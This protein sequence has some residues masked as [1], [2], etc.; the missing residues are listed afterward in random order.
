MKEELTENIHQAFLQ[1]EFATKLLT[2]TE[3]Y[4][5][6]KNDFDTNVVIEDGKHIIPFNHSAFNSYDDLIL[7]AENNYNITLGFTAIVLDSSFEKIG[8]AADPKNRTSNGMLRT[9]IYM[10]RC[11][12]AH[13]MMF[14]KW[15]VKG[16]YSEILT[17]HLRD[18][19]L[20]LD[21][22]DKDDTAFKIG[23]IGGLRIYLSI[24]E[25][26]CQLINES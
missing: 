4:G 24:K 19:I 2:Y 23:D 15:K 7:A 20:K 22:S 11:A 13:D 5:I 25:K 12:Y 21:L 17:I 1:L 10:I 6:N 26:V 3:L 8:I 18:E 9:L 16:D 14:P